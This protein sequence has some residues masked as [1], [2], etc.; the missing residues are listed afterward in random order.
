MTKSLLLLLPSLM[1]AGCSNAGNE[2]LVFSD[3]S[4]EPCG[5]KP[6]C[7]STIET[8]PDFNLSVFRLNRQGQ[9]NWEAIQHIALSLPGASLGEQR[10][11]YI[12]VECRSK[13]FGFVDDFEVRLNGEE[14]IV[15]SESRTGYSDFGVNRERADLFRTRLADA[16]YLKN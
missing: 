8:R 2:A 3:R 11:H 12:R 7:V 14:L 16:K 10:E 1:L 9:N 13:I 4:L 15:R 5:E 6:N